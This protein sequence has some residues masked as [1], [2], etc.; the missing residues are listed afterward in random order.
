MLES[1]THQRRSARTRAMCVLRILATDRMAA[2]A[3][4]VMLV[5]GGAAVWHGGGGAVVPD[6]GDIGAWLSNNKKGSVVHANGASGKAD[7]QVRL[8][9][10]Q[11]HPLAVNQDGE[12]VLV[13]DT[14]TGV[15]NRIDPAQLSVTQS[16]DYGTVTTRVVTGSGLAYV[17]DAERSRVQRIDL[18]DLS[19]V[20]DPIQ[21]DTAPGS[22]GIDREGTLWVAAP[23]RGALVPIANG[24]V[25]TP[26][27]VGQPGDDVTVTIAGGIPVATNATRG[28]MT[29]VSRGGGRVTVNLPTPA[30]AEKPRALLAPSRTE[31]PLVPIVAGD[32][33]EL[34]VVDTES[35][36]PSSVTFAGV[37]GHDL[38]TP[39]V[40]G[41]R[42]YVP[43]QSTG[44]LL[45]YD[46]ATDQ[47]L[48]QI[49]VTTH[50]SKVDLFVKDGLLWV[51]NADGPEAL[52][53]DS[54]G[55][56]HRI[57]KDDK[58][59][60]GALPTTSPTRQPPSGE[61]QPVKLPPP[62]QVPTTDNQ[63]KQPP[64][65]NPPP[66]NLPPRP[67]A[68][69]PKPPPPPPPP[70]APPPP[71]NQAPGTVRQT[72]QAGSILVTF[73][74][75]SAISQVI[76]YTLSGQPSSAT[77]KPPTIPASGTAYKFE[78]TGL[79]CG[80]T[81]QFSVT[82]HY[83][84]GSAST[85]AGS[86]VRPCVA[87]SAPRNLSLSTSTERQLG[88]DWD[89][90]TDD[91]GADPGTSRYDVSWNGGRHPGLNGTSDT[92]TGLMNF[93]SYTVTV[94]ARN[95]AGASEPP[96]T[97]SVTLKAG[98]WGGTTWHPLYDLSVRSGPNTG[99]SRILVFPPGS[100]DPVT[101]KCIVN[102]GPWTDPS[103]NG[104]N[105]STWFRITQPVTGYIASGYV[106]TSP[107]VWKGPC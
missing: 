35:G 71:S 42:I 57:G 31:G 8:R 80:K 44:Q 18:T 6:I 25:G 43:D 101:V 105:G 50:P 85:K 79:R 1:L 20:G 10:A 52:S 107:N 58:K 91:G 63:A 21:L 51:N 22:A 104:P 61:P 19:A 62:V 15:V 24:A 27:S 93:D 49:T 59:L 88:V 70:P 95:F 74:P 11:G 17:I 75:V 106:R 37:A 13:T 48:D 66:V 83:A 67:S 78:V 14:V 97:K 36:T 33:G 100:S 30:P 4:V 82:A 77:V 72:P 2:I 47:L 98:P 68:S 46:A 96:A 69:A 45:V 99:S 40:L 81:Y 32:T 54:T 16:V 23:G 39:A 55:N 60:P 64:P 102:G 84:A 56:V 87:P 53:V 7:A 103:G 12:T 90:P 41:D 65:V 26:V 29:V 28:T 3:T 89:P 34:V 86:A 94:A 73:T 9:D 38:G 5:V 76:N 92:I